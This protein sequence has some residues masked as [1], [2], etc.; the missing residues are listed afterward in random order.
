MSLWNRIMGPVL[1]AGL[2]LSA[3]TP[4]VTIQS[5][6]DVGEW[7]IQANGASV[8]Q[9]SVTGVITDTNAISTGAVP[10][11]FCSLLCTGTVGHTFHFQYAGSQPATFTLT[12]QSTG[13]T[14]TVNTSNIASSAKV[15]GTNPTFVAGGTIAHEGGTIGPLATNLPSD[16]YI[17]SFPA[18]QIVDDTTGATSA[19]FIFTI[20]IH[21]QNGIAIT[22]SSDLDFGEIVT[23]PSSGQVSLAPSPGRTFSGGVTGGPRGPTLAS[24][25][26]MGKTGGSS[27]SRRYQITFLGSGT[28]GQG[29]VTLT[30]GSNSMNA[31]LQA[32]I[33]NAIPANGRGVLNSSTGTQSFEVGGT[34][35][36]GANQP[37]G[38]YS[39]IFT[40]VVTYN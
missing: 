6:M 27:A 17:G 20:S 3:Q 18:L 32:Y 40:V 4:T 14:I 34:L 35:T 12:G 15:S 28:P 39:G 7:V 23:S 1:L 13:Q 26:V 33:G 10:V 8:S 36:V 9:N 5:N 25:N 22:K 31:S 24:F 38:D 21:I 37:D 2:A 19:N 11:L 16:T 30:S 29:S